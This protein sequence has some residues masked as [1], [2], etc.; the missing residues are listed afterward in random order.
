MQY[1]ATGGGGQ[2]G[3][4]KKGEGGIV[5]GNGTG[6][7]RE[8]SDRGGHGE[9]GELGI[10]LPNWLRPAVEVNYIRPCSL[11]MFSSLCTV[12][13]VFFTIHF[14]LMTMMMMIQCRAHSVS[15]MGEADSVVWNAEMLC[16]ENY[17]LAL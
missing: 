14:K 11:L 1:L 12:T 9:K 7:E 17:R 2:K 10:G 4:G 8:K 16:S 5:D 15:A 6:R 13:A 3:E